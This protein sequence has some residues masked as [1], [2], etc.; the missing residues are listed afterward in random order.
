[1][2]KHLLALFVV[3]IAAINADAQDKVISGSQ[4]AAV[5]STQPALIYVVPIK[6]P[7]MDK[8]LAYFIRHSVELAKA[9]N[10]A[11][12]IFEIDTPGGAVGGGEEYTIGICNSIDRAAPITTVAYITHWA[13]SA[14]A[15]VSISTDKIVMKQVASIGSAEVVGAEEHQE[16]YTSAIRTEFK[17]RAEKK[18]YSANLMMAMVDKDLEVHEVLV[19][20]VRQ[21]MTPQE[22]KEARNKGKLV[23][24]IKLIIASGKLLNLSAGD[25]LKYGLASAIKGERAEIPPLLGITNF[26]FKEVTPTWSEHLVMYLTSQVVS[27]ILILAGLLAAYMA[28]QSPGTGIPEAIAVVCFALVFFGHYLIGLAEV[29]EVLLFILG[30]GLIG[31]EVFLLPGFGV[32]AISGAILVLVS[33]IMSMQGFVIPDMKGAPWQLVTL[34]RNFIV[35]GLAFS[36]SLIIFV[37]MV[38][39]LPSVPFFS[40]LIL[41][42]DVKTSAGFS[43]VAMDAAPLLGKKG[44]VFT[45]LRPVGK[46]VVLDASGHQTD[47]NLEVVTEGDFINKDEAVVIIEIDGSRI[48][49]E[50]TKV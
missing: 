17:A 3:L 39:Y 35:V 37:I 38:R 23:E 8:G 50:K 36:L 31:V 45:A 18:G 44:V 21:F 16:K 32:F 28:Y 41:S 43:S 7:I 20:G 42:A 22:I 34:E 9:E 30:M 11:L 47:Q 46:I 40:H 6:G 48:V 25:A 4:I 27:G 2:L 15:L 13:W 5:S 10:A 14:G 49:V 12:I 24:E 29:T 26:K 33:L 19:D 1:M